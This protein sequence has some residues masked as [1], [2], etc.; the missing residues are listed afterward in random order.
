MAYFKRNGLVLSG[1]TVPLGQIAVAKE[2][3]KEITPAVKYEAQAKVKDEQEPTVKQPLLKKRLEPRSDFT[4]SEMALNSFSERLMVIIERKIEHR[5]NTVKRELDVKY[6]SAIQNTVRSESN[7]RP[8]ESNVKY[9]FPY[10]EL[11][12]KY[13]QQS[14][15]TVNDEEEDKQEDALPYFTVRDLK[16]DE[17]SMKEAPEKNKPIRPVEFLDEQEPDPELS[18]EQETDPESG[19]EETNQTNKTEAMTNE[20]P[21]ITLSGTSIPELE[22]KLNELKTETNEES[23]EE[24]SEALKDEPSEYYDADPEIVLH[25]IESG[26][27]RKIKKQEAELNQFKKLDNPLS[28]WTL[29]SVV[30]IQWVSK[31]LRALAESLVKLSNYDF[32]DRQTLFAITEAFNRMIKTTQFKGLPEDY[33]FT[34]LILQLFE[35][36][37]Q[38]SI[39]NRDTEQIRFRLS[40][41][42]KAQLV[43]VR[44][45]LSRYTEKLKFSELTFV[46]EK[47]LLIPISAK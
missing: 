20:K 40:L 22:K 36:L 29:V 35:K 33:P 5:I 23:E 41:H 16:P 27:L 13:I 38:L 37:K 46:D 34:A 18:E 7:V 1:G 42:K 32:I 17:P 43:A 19:E 39:E 10:Q 25:P 11:N 28:F 44:N 24:D 6:G 8:T 15:N 2:Q 30:R 26:L 12:V 21:Q 45:F 47:D 31:R 9:C 3:A 4:I 14:K